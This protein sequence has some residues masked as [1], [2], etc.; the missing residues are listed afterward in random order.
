MVTLQAYG[1]AEQSFKKI[2][3]YLPIWPGTDDS[4]YPVNF[5]QIAT[6]QMAQQ[7]WEAAEDS[8]NKSVSLFDP[9]IQKALKSDNEF[10]RTENAGNLLGS[11]ARSNVYLGIVY[12]REG[13]TAEALKT[14]ELAYN[15]ATQEHVPPTFYYEVVKIGRSI[16]QASG[17]GDAVAKW[18]QRSPR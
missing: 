2:M 13:R 16:A 6:A 9:Q 14:A 15:E 18:S 5:R 3:E 12:L 11:K 7:H 17:D 10:W 4:D 1:E 8:L